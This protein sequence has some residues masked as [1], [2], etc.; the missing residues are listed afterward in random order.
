MNIRTKS[1]VKPISSIVPEM[2]KLLLLAAC[3][4]MSIYASAATLRVN[5]TAG[6]GAQFTTFE[7]AQGSAEDGDVII[8]DGSNTSYGKITVSKRLTL[9]GPGYF[10]DVNDP[11][12][13][14]H[15]SAKFEEVNLECDGVKVTGLYVSGG[16]NMKADNLV[17]T[18]CYTNRVSL[19]P[20]YSYKEKHITN[21]IIHQNFISSGISGDSYSASATYMQVTNNI[22]ANGYNTMFCNMDNSVIS[23]NTA[24]GSESGVRSLTNCVIEN[25][26]SCNIEDSYYNNKDNTYSNNLSITKKEYGATNNDAVMKATDEGLASDKGA[27]S[28]D[29]PYVLSG[30]STGP[31]LQDLIIP[32]SVVQG[33]DL[34]VTVKIGTSR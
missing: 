15:A 21:G 18:R 2:K 13:E 22:I 1:K 5:N 27:F 10:L 30:L 11:S 7:E 19:C 31:V 4:T 32:E 12:N 24:I 25:N 33:E 3:I 20:L 17:V 14:G 26:I 9:Q 34:K 16:I 29:D 28:G 23:R 6:S 8:F